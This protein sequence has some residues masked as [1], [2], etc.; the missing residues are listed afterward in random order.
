MPAPGENEDQRDSRS[1]GPQKGDPKLPGP[2]SWLPFVF[3]SIALLFY[4][5]SNAGFQ[6]G[7]ELAYSDFLD[8][9][10]TGEVQ[11]VEFKGIH[12]SG[13]F[14]QES[15]VGE[16]RLRRRCRSSVMTRSCRSCA[17]KG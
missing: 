9:V 4:Q 11:S 2:R 13:E 5:F 1:R 15:G 7:E 17:K 3:L 14:R 12:L 6:Q 8:R 10:G 16:A